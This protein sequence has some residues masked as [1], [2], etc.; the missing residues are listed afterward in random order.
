MK[1]AEAMQKKVKRTTGSLL[2]P[3]ISSDSFIDGQL[4]QTQQS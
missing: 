1:H 4:V 2:K 3:E